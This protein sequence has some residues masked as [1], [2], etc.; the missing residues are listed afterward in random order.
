MTEVKYI[1]AHDTGTEV[2]KAAIVRPDAKIIGTASAE[3]GVSYPNP[4]WAEQ[5]PQVYW[6]AIVKTTRE[7]LTKTKVKPSDIS[8]IVFDAM[9][10]S[11]VPVD[12]KGK[13]LRPII[14]WL[15]VRA[16]KQA[17]NFSML[18]DLMEL[19]RRPVIPQMSAKDQIPKVMWIKEKEPE[20]FART[21]KFVDV[22]DYLIYKCVG[23]FFVDWSCASVYGFLNLNTKRIEKDILQ[24]IGL[25]E[26]RL[27]KVVKTT[28]VVGNLTGQAAR[29][30][31]LTENTQVVC[32]C[33]DVPAVGI[34]SGAIK[35][36][37]PH[38]YM[39]SSGWIALHMDKPLFDLSGVGTICSG[40]PSKLLLLGQMENAG[41]CLK[42]FKDQLCDAEKRT[43]EETGKGVYQI[44]DEEA[45][46]SPPGSKCLIFAPWILGERCPFIDSKARGGFMNLA[47]NHT[48]KDMVR[49]VMEGVAYNTRWVQEIFE[50]NLKQ[51]ITSLNGVGGGAKSPI[52]LQILADVLG[53]PI[54]QIHVL[55]DVG[56]VGVAMVAAVGLG[57]HKD[58]DSLEKVFKTKAT[59]NPVEENM[60]NYARL[61]DAFKKVYKGLTPI[62]NVLNK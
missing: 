12:D 34:G 36:G 19:L 45:N 42:W 51:K 27:A 17:D 59:F 60:K 46:Q 52:W 37:N 7:V 40:D 8:A 54:K 33:G 55:Q 16:S 58:F 56:T 31:G 13:A 41:A 53:K 62:H 24:K 61:F 3:Y 26:E 9:M 10:A 32:G 30:L 39:G 22:K 49:A 23:D 14:L 20:V 15:D 11:I 38:L 35:N 50:V 25:S 48:K 47:L 43:A 4:G 1:L 29:E 18:F 28:D 2:S 57:V 6:E 21:N 5:D 44:L